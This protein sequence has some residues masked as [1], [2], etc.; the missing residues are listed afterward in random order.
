METTTSPNFNYNTNTLRTLPRKRR[1]RAAGEVSITCPSSCVYLNSELRQA[2]AD[3]TSVEKDPVYQN[4]CSEQ[5]L[6]AQLE[7]SK[8]PPQHEQPTVRQRQRIHLTFI[9]AT[10]A[11]VDETR[12]SVVMSTFVGWYS[13]LLRSKL[14]L[15]WPIYQ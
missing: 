13:E 6:Q 8:R 9:R 12:E 11:E 1:P 4:T 2:T 15:N 10:I 5:Q 3:T 14:G 7:C